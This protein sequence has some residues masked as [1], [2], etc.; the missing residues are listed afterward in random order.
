LQQNR[1]E[2]TTPKVDGDELDLVD[3]I[4][5]IRRA[6]KRAFLATGWEHALVVH[7]VWQTDDSAALQPGVIC[8]RHALSK[9]SQERTL[10]HLS[11]ALGK[12]PILYDPT[13]VV[14]RLHGLVRLAAEFRAAAPRDIVQIALEPRSR[15]VYVV[16][17]EAGPDERDLR[18][19]QLLNTLA[20][21]TQRWQ[22]TGIDC[23]LSIRLCERLPPAALL[24]LVDRKS[25]RRQILPRL[26]SGW[27]KGLAVLGV[28]TAIATPAAADA[29]K[30]INATALA[31]VVVN[32]SAKGDFGGS[33]DAPVTESLGAQIDIGV[34]ADSY[35][36]AGG[37]LFIRD[38]DIG[39]LGLTASV[40]ALDEKVMYRVGSKAEYYL[41]R[42][43]LAGTVGYQSLDQAD[44]AYGSVDLSFYASPDLA[45]RAGADLSPDLQLYNV[46]AEWRPGFDALPGLSIYSD[47]EHDSH[48]GNAA[49]IGLIYHF[50]E[51]GVSLMER[52]RTMKTSTSIFNRA[53]LKYVS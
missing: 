49:R 17:R 14:S 24:V 27:R 15:T 25:A 46:G 43:T 23:H 29:V 34:G 30:E 32:S 8:K 33:F 36:G 28:S 9:L 45:L 48:G 5:K 22:R 13:R 12:D 38:P 52:D 26:A 39:L 37:Q 40:E 7:S 3:L 42:L 6:D 11:N 44:G 47:F 20:K 50:G 16:M 18:K 35:I 53:P 21:A 31:G 1:I 19:G 4:Q 51:H 41:N 10:E 2:Y